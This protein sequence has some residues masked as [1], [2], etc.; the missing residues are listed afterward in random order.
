MGHLFSIICKQHAD[1]AIV[2][3]LARRGALEESGTI[4]ITRCKLVSFIH[5]NP[6]G[7]QQYLDK[8]WMSSVLHDG[9]W[10]C[11]VVTITTTITITI[12]ITINI[13]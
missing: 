2:S 1:N 9:E 3:E 6:I 12:T 5:I 8:L 13:A 11:T 7:R 4:T 10:S